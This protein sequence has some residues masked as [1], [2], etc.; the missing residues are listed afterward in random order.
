M[1]PGHLE[2]RAQTPDAGWVAIL[3]SYSLELVVFGQGGSGCLIS[4]RTHFVPL[5]VWLLENQNKAGR[6]C[7]GYKPPL[8]HVE[9]LL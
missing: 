2:L 3:T 9:D 8:P 6:C 4:T 5:P 7:R 1:T